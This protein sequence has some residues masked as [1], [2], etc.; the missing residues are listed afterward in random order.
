MAEDTMAAEQYQPSRLRLKYDFTVVVVDECLLVSQVE[1]SNS[2]I[3]ALTGSDV[4]GF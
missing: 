1:H 4:V 2:G 3:L